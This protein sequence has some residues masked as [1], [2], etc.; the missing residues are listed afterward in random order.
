MAENKPVMPLGLPKKF[1][2]AD[3]D[4]SVKD[5]LESFDRFAL[6]LKLKN[7]QLKPVFRMLL[8]DN[9]ARYFD[10]VPD[11]NTIAEVRQA[12][13]GRYRLPLLSRLHLIAAL[14]QRNQYSHEKTLDFIDYI[15]YKGSELDLTD[16]TV[17]CIVLKGMNHEVRAHVMQGEYKTFRTNHHH[18]HES[19]GWFVSAIWRN[20]GRYVRK[21]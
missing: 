21:R 6:Y 14:W 17:R 12:F 19:R 15:S 8:E 4:Y 16:E 1:N 11:K 5:F 10:S 13:E 20:S 9:A 2:G 18:D 7:D 3:H